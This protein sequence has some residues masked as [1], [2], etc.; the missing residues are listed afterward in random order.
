MISEITVI[1]PNFNKATYLGPAVDSAL[2]QTLENLE[3]I[4]VDDGSTDD[5][6]SVVEE[7]QKG[8]SRLRL[9]AHEKNKG[10]SAALNTGIR[11]ARSNYVTFLG[12]DDLFARERCQTLSSKLK[13]EGRPC[14]VYTDSIHLDETQTSVSAQF[15][16]ALHRPEGIIFGDV[17]VG[18]WRFTLASIGLSK[19]CFDAVG[20]HDEDLRYAEDLDIVLRL[21]AKFPF[22]FERL[23]TYGWRSHGAST[24]VAMISARRMKYESRVLERNLLNNL[25]ALDSETKRKSFNRLFGCY[26]R[27]GQW[28]RLARMSFVDRQAFLSMVTIPARSRRFRN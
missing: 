23:S 10:V 11:N 7:I 8:D 24:S 22:Y 13:A 17:L 27:S 19:S 26:V 15:S 4:V 21:S 16:T 25:S 28:M 3:V 14:V 18:A 20:L 12:S 5:S 6:V 9:I 2:Q 1:I